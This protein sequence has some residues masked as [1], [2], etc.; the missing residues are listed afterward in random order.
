MRHGVVVTVVV[1]LPLS[2]MLVFFS[3]S[4]FIVRTILLDR[5]AQ[6][7]QW[8]AYHSDMSY[9]LRTNSTHIYYLDALYAGVVNLHHIR[10]EADVYYTFVAQKWIFMR[11]LD[12]YKNPVR[13]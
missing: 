13:I 11:G 3:F 5:S 1:A 7:V 8:I 12:I 6:D 9:S 10:E 4:F 2:S